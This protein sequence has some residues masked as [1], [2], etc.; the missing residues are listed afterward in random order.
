MNKKLLRCFKVSFLDTFI[1]LVLILA[2]IY[3]I[4]LSPKIISYIIDIIIANKIQ[5][6]IC[7]LVFAYFIIS[8]IIV[9][10]NLILKHYFKNI[11][12]NITNS[13]RILIKDNI[14]SYDDKFFKDK[15]LGNL[16]EYFENNISTIDNFLSKIFFNFIIYFLIVI[17]TIVSFYLESVLMGVIFSIY[18]FL[19]VIMLLVIIFSQKDIL[20]KNK[21]ITT[22]NIG[23]YSEWINNSSELDMLDGYNYIKNKMDI[24]NREFLNTETKAQKYLYKIWS[25]TLFFS[26][27]STILALFLGGG[28]YFK[29]IISFG[30]IYTLYSYSTLLKDPI[31]NMQA[32]MRSYLNFKACLKRINKIFEYEPEVKFGAYNTDKKIQNINITNLYYSYNN[33]DNYCLKNINIELKYN[34]II[35]IMGK[36]GS[37]KTT[38]CKLLCKYIQKI[39]GKIY[40]NNT[41]IE[42][43]SEEYINKSIV[44]VCPN[45][46]IFNDT[47]K[48]NITFFNNDISDKYL[49]DKLKDY[50]LL[51]YFAQYGDNFLHT[52]IN[53]DNLSVG[54]K[55]I[56]CLLRTILNTRANLIIFDETYSKIDKNIIKLFFEILYNIVKDKIIIIVSHNTETIN[57]CDRMIVFEDGII[58]KST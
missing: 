41:E 29:G 48:N 55:Q 1:V 49:L 46:N 24:M 8:N 34:S 2:Q 9:I 14:L 39:K 12:L 21:E 44:Y 17:F 7:I 6:S 26:V 18:V 56:I 4:F 50:N 20:L 23:K 11:S 16:L 31:E 37:G 43:F 45:G 53:N 32:H 47:I 52:N 15:N 54:E 35:G 25:L 28:L 51:Q 30:T 10:F 33:D 5:K 13:I 42:D 58:K 3:L 22:F 40:I 38:F 19:F 57:Y 36:S 27:F